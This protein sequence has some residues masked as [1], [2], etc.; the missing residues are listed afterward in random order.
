MQDTHD[1][2]PG[3]INAI[4]QQKGEAVKLPDAQGLVS[5]EMGVAAQSG[6]GLE[7]RPC[8]VVSSSETKRS[9]SST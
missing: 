9:A 8:K 4:E 2:D 7:H 3:A 5:K 1:L 6:P